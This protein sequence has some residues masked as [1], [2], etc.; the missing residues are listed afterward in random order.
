MA[1]P[2]VSLTTEILLNQ[3]NPQLLVHVTAEDGTTGTGETWWGTYQPTAEPGTPVGPMAA[4]VD[5]VMAHLCIGWDSSDIAGLWQ[6]LYRASY[7]YGPEGIT[8]SALAGIDLAMWERPT[9]R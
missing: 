8:S 4:M 7:Q 3:N 6:H 1:I 5:Q 9:N 2:I